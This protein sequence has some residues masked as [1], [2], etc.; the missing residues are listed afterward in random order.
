MKK[1]YAQLQRRLLPVLFLNIWRGGPYNSWSP[2]FTF[3]YGAEPHFKHGLHYRG[4]R[5]HVEHSCESGAPD[6][7]MGHISYI[8]PT[9]YSAENA[10]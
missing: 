3:T 10:H 6:R 9:A 8:P 7:V 5:H 1:L 2:T 4:N